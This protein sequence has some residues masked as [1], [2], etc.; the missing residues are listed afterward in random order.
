MIDDEYCMTPERWRSFRSQ[1]LHKNKLNRSKHFSTFCEWYKKLSSKYNGH[2]TYYEKIL[3]YQRHLSYSEGC[4]IFNFFKL[5]PNG[6]FIKKF[7][8]EYLSDD[9]P[10]RQDIEDILKKNTVKKWDDNFVKPLW[11]NQEDYI[12]FLTQHLWR[13]RDFYLLK[14]VVEYS[15]ENNET[16]IIK[17]HII[18][19]IGYE[20]NKV[21]N[22]IHK[23]CDEHSNVYFID[24]TFETYP[25]IPSSKYIW[26]INSSV[27]LAALMQNKRYSYF[28]KNLDYAFHIS[29]HYADSIEEAVKYDHSYEKF[30]SKMSWY[31]D[32]MIIDVN[33]ENHFYL[34]DKRFDRFYNKGVSDV[35]F[36][37]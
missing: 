7:D 12:L 21:I 10:I 27:G 35:E 37:Q 26:S 24:R 20:Y 34:L 31:Y 3:P 29:A 2:L 15:V 6:H 11:M 30:L 8:L 16:L 33:D 22:W 9:Y 19:P 25:L 17:E 18:P 5:V 4:P 36:F 13:K 32:K 1:G 23:K 14:E 28:E